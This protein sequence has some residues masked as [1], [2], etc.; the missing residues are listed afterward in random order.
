AG[1]LDEITFDAEQFVKKQDQLTYC[2]EVVL[3]ALVMAQADARRERFDQERLAEM[4]GL[5]G[6]LLDEFDDFEVGTPLVEGD[7]CAPE[8]LPVL[9]P[10]ELK[11]DWQVAAP[12]LSVGMRNPLDRAAAAVLAHLLIVHGIGARV[13]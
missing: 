13:L 2:D 10:A 9:S 4:A 12:V 6:E 7:E 3:P 8:R 11:S 5:V 1:D